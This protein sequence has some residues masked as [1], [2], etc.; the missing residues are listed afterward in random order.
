MLGVVVNMIVHGAEEGTHEWPPMVYPYPPWWVIRKSDTFFCITRPL[1]VRFA[2][3]KA[4]RWLIMIQY[5]SCTVKELEG[6]IMYT[7]LYRLC[8]GHYS[9]PNLGRRLGV[10]CRLLHISVHGHPFDPI[11]RMA[12]MHI[13]VAQLYYEGIRRFYDASIRL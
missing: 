9:Y 5:Y 12:I 7:Y 13:T 4:Y 2:W 8:F 11:Q 1:L 3:S 6:F 10:D